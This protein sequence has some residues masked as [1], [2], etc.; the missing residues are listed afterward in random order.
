L[1]D[2]RI[3]VGIEFVAK[4]SQG[5]KLEYSSWCEIS[6]DGTTSIVSLIERSGNDFLLSSQSPNM[7]ND[8]LQKVKLGKPQ[9][10]A[11]RAFATISNRN[12]FSIRATEIVCR[13]GLPAS[14]RTNE[15]TIVI[16]RIIRAGT[17]TSFLIPRAGGAESLTCRVKDFLKTGLIEQRLIDAFGLTAAQ[18]SYSRLR[19]DAVRLGVPIES[20]VESYIALVKSSPSY[21]R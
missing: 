5:I 8:Y 14:R 10:E 16:E 9:I 13:V 17:W 20:L 12:E 2:N 21:L 11:D 19:Q 4:N 7:R 1:N 6:P 15:K 3:S 18:S